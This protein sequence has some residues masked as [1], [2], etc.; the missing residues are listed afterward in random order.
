MSRLASQTAIATGGS[1]PLTWLTRVTALAALVATTS[2]GSPVEPTERIPFIAFAR[3]FDGF[4]TWPSK[5]FE[6]P[7]TTTTHIGGQ[8]TVYINQLP[9]ADATSFPVGTLIVKET[10]ADGKLFARVKRGSGYN[11]TG[12]VDWEWF[13]LS[14]AA[15]GAVVIEWHGFGPPAGEEYGGDASGGCNSC[16]KAAPANDYVLSPWLT[17]AGATLPPADQPDGGTANVIA[18][19]ASLVP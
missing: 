18:K 7:P 17:L 13:E 1:A 5:T 11:Q 15:G 9:A 10:A 6:S 19:G 14:E 4:R 2:C 8:R 3:D 12:A 16:H